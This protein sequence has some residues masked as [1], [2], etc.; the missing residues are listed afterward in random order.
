MKL[1]HHQT[2]KVV[3]NV[4]ATFVKAAVERMRGVAERREEKTKTDL[5]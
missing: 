2:L 3:N 5:D 4:T 1:L